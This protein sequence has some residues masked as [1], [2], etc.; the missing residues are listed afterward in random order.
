MKN[1]S[2]NSKIAD[3]NKDKIN[4]KFKILG[5][6]DSSY[7]GAVVSKFVSFIN[8][9]KIKWRKM[10]LHYSTKEASSSNCEEASQQVLFT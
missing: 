5:P 6:L 9:G 2:Q 7:S 1:F 10:A 3:K 4:E 8:K